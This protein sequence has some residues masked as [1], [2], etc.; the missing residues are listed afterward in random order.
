MA[1]KKPSVARTSVSLPAGLKR[2]MDKVKEPVNWSA[3]ACRAFENEL[4]DIAS[5]KE[6]KDMNDV[7]DRLRSSLRGNEEKAYKEGFAFGQWWASHRAE[8]SF[9]QRLER[10]HGKLE[11]DT[12]YGWQGFFDS[13]F[14]QGQEFRDAPEVPPARHR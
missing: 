4:A 2:R 9:L 7:V 11:Y 10:L 6:K 1:K 12:S 8:A 13:D 3:L 14:G 5:K